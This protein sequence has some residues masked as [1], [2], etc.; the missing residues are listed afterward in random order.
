MRA[1]CAFQVSRLILHP[2]SFSRLWPLF[3]G[4]CVGPMLNP[5]SSAA[6]S[7]VPLQTAT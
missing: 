7:C 1:Q 5:H 4:G 2:P 3:V 6:F